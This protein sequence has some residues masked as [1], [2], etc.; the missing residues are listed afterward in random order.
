MDRI[1]LDQLIASAAENAGVSAA[2][3]KKVIYQGENSG[4]TSDIPTNLTNK[5]TGAT[6]IAQ[7][8]PKTFESLIAQGSLSKGSDILDPATNLLAGAKVL[9]DGLKINNGN[10]A[11]AVAHYNAGTATGRTVAAGGVA[12]TKETRDYLKRTGMTTEPTQLAS[13]SAG[14]SAGTTTRTTSKDF[15]AMDPS[16]FL[17]EFAAKLPIHMQGLM[18]ALKAQAGFGETA[19]INM[20]QAGA[21]G[22]KAIIAKGEAEAQ[23]VEH[24]NA[25]ADSF[26][27]R[28][29][30]GSVVQAHEA[31]ASAR[32]TMDALRP[33]IAE[34][35]AVT[36]WDDPLRWVVNQFTLP[37]LV[38]TYNN[39]NGQ[40]KAMLKRIED[41]QRIVRQQQALDLAPVGDLIR[42]TAA[43]TA[44]GKSF[45]MIAK[46]NE[47]RAGSQHILA[48]SIMQEMG[49]DK[50]L[51]DGR[52]QL[53]NM[54]STTSANSAYD[55]QQST[56]SAKEAKGVADR[57]PL[58]DQVNLK[59]L[60][61]G[62][63]SFR[64]A[65]WMQMD[66][67]RKAELTL[68][69]QY[70]SIGTGLGD[71]YREIIIRG[72]DQGLSEKNPALFKF[73]D[74][75]I[76]GKDYDKAKTLAGQDKA[77]SDFNKMSSIDQ[78]A[79]I[80]DKLDTKW[81]GEVKGATVNGVYQPVKMNDPGISES[82]P[83][84][85]NINQLA[86]D[87][88]LA[89]NPFMATVIA[90][91]TVNSMYAATDRDLLLEGIGRAKA[92][93]KDIPKIAEQLQEVYQ[94]GVLAQYAKGGAFTSGMPRPT[95]YG[96]GVEGNYTDE[97][98]I[99]RGLQMWD[100]GAIEHFLMQNIR[101]VAGYKLDSRPAGEELKGFA[102][103]MTG[104]N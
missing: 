95:G 89:E 9:A 38:Q 59:Q 71:T 96:L 28:G 39:A 41:D 31:R 64:D 55:R 86:L 99:T 19:A 43:A 94:K 48:Q 79:F 14:S 21:A 49:A 69:A 36:A 97:S 104:A 91:K 85:L 10:E 68:N 62:L 20:E 1:N 74:S 84:K 6:G 29:P 61:L 73:Y 88:Q 63:P 56:L 54:L 15:G 13:S 18:S 82:N 60:T 27:V 44:V 11:G 80:L 46:A 90:R 34:E 17:T 5:R 102:G 4:Y 2:L 78:R 8:M 26:G 75:I 16:S 100:R 35:S 87:P 98:G 22:S 53:A 50:S 93:V 23:Q 12:P 40:D 33:K 30:S 72:A 24:S 37:N 65:D 51:L 25:V 58:L 66:S 70:P 45:E 52:M 42:Q 103:R 67:K 32:A 92:N 3:Y 101:A 57:K 47:M 81:R 7:V 77:D 83:Y 76:G